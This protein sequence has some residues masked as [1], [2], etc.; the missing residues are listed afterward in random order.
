MAEIVVSRLLVRRHLYNDLLNMHMRIQQV[1]R[2]LN[3]YLNSLEN[4]PR[5]EG[6][7]IHESI[8]TQIAPEINLLNGGVH[9]CEEAIKHLYCWIEVVM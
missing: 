4:E 6:H 1:E 5:D 9:T 2:Q 8:Q 7:F 3:D